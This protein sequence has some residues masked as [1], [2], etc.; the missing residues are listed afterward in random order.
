METAPPLLSDI[1]YLKPSQEEIRAEKRRAVS[2]FYPAFLG[3]LAIWFHYSDVS[4]DL[5]RYLLLMVTLSSVIPCIIGIY[6]IVNPPSK[7]L[8][9]KILI[10]CDPKA[11][12]RRILIGSAASGI[13]FIYIL[14][15]FS[16]LFL[17][18][19]LSSYQ[20]EEELKKENKELRRELCTLKKQNEAN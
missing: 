13:M 19:L 15:L 12:V 17:S 11:M 7:K 16:I 10:S 9:E 20:D 14:S 8:Y 4:S 18:P 6:F 3:S 1:E 5:E 2:L